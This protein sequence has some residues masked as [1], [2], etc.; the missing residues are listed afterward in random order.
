MVECED[1][2]LLCP[3]I[4]GADRSLLQAKRDHGSRN[5]VRAG[6]HSRGYLGGNRRGVKWESEFRLSPAPLN[7]NSPDVIS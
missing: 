7:G 1:R 5:A 3:G 6:P 2:A 4:A